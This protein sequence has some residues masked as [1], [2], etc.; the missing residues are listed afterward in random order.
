MASIKADLSTYFFSD[1]GSRVALYPNQSH[2]VRR[3]ERAGFPPGVDLVTLPKAAL[4]YRVLP[5]PVLGGFGPK[6]MARHR[7]GEFDRS[8]GFG[9]AW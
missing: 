5:H 8:L 1:Y 6:P 9:I 7:I 4:L 2:L 3:H